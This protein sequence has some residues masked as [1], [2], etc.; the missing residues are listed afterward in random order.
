MVLRILIGTGVLMKR[1]EDILGHS[2]INYGLGIEGEDS[3]SG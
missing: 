3:D 1:I 2:K